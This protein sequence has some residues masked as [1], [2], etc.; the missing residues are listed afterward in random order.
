MPSMTWPGGGWSTSPRMTAC[1]SMLYFHP[2]PPQAQEFAE[3]QMQIAAAMHGEAEALSASSPSHASITPVWIGSDR[4]GSDRTGW[5]CNGWRGHSAPL[6]T[7]MTPHSRMC[8]CS[9]G[10][11]HC[12][13]ASSQSEQGAILSNPCVSTMLTLHAR[14]LGSSC[15]AHL[16]TMPAP[17]S[18]SCPLL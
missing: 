10:L 5:G 13:V 4:I 9:S 2:T 7:S 18:T 1:S 14:A 6:P 11:G 12:T 8:T 15:R 3:Q 16:P 17:P